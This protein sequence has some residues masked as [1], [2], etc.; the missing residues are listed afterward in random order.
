MTLRG[1]TMTFRNSAQGRGCTA[2]VTAERHRGPLRRA[3]RGSRR[4]AQPSE[5]FGS[6]LCRAAFALLS[7]GRGG[8]RGR[9][10]DC[11]PRN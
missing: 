1:P 9:D 11:E 4:Q 6:S 8:L 10:F 5:P 3:P 2:N 7:A